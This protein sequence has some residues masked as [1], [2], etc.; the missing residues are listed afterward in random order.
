MDM[1]EAH[2]IFD[3]MDKHQSGKVI[4]DTIID[5]LK[6]NSINLTPLQGI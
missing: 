5:L 2:Y 1:D 4:Y 6:E 3:S